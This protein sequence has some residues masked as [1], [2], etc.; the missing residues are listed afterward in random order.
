[1]ELF[2]SIEGSQIQV[3]QK[4]FFYGGSCLFSQEKQGGRFRCFF[5]GVFL[6]CWMNIVHFSNG[7]KH[8][9]F[10]NVQHHP[11]G[12]VWNDGFCFIL[13]WEWYLYSVRGLD[14]HRKR[15]SNVKIGRNRCMPC[16]KLTAVHPSP[17]NLEGFRISHCVAYVP[18]NNRWKCSQAISYQIPFRNAAYLPKH[19]TCLDEPKLSRLVLSKRRI[20]GSQNSR[21]LV[22]EIIAI[23]LGKAKDPHFYNQE[24]LMAYAIIL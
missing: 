11:Q 8:V 13:F 6:G 18:A 12:N 5:A 1:M 2:P 19:D 7:G 3:L 15:P 20:P 24:L 21:A 16:W 17:C 23:Y 9:K 14:I 4:N 22:F 10:W